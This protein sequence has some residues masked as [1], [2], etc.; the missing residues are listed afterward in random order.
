[1]TRTL[2]VVPEAR[3][4]R[5]A[6]GM[7]RVSDERG[8]GDA[9]LS[10]A[11]QRRSIE[12]YASRAGYDVVDWV[13][14][15]DT[16]GSR[17]RSAWWPRLDQTI[18]RI[19][20]GEA[21]VIVVW[22]FSRA[23]RHR[24]K[25]AMALDRVETAGGRLESATESTDATPAGRLSRGMIGEIAAYE[26]EI[27][28]EN[29]KSAHRIRTDRG[30][31][32]NGKPRWGYTY[33]TDE[34]LHRPDPD[35]GP[36]LAELYRRYVAGESVYSLVRWLNAAG[37]RTTP[38]YSKDGPGRWTDRSLRRMLDS[39]FG[40]GLILVHGEHR[41]GVHD[42]VIGRDLWEAY[43]DARTRRRVTRSSERSQYLLSGLV[44]C[45]H[46]LDGDST[47]GSAMTAGQFGSSHQPKYRC[48]GARE[49]GLHDGGYVTAA[50]LEEAV[51]D[52]LRDLAADV[53]AASAKAAAASRRAAR[54]REQDAATMEAEA[55]RIGEQLVRATRQHVAGVV[56]EAAYL[57]VRDELQEQL[58]VLEQRRR[59][60][61]VASRRGTADVVARELLAEW[62]VLSVEH[63]RGMLRTLIAR[64]E[65]R[66]GRPRAVV[67]IVPE[68]SEAVGDL[69][70]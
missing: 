44:R 66:P 41:D 56:P 40:A 11:I 19:E 18:D 49:A 55:A 23:A 24:L 54:R 3:T 7:V 14:G 42:P 45:V 46:V 68:W 69:T 29:W 2:T 53:S 39:G 59:T 6:I 15:I 48:K 61:Q 43:Q 57:E 65:V 58:E 64:V 4:R 12:E 32:A 70:A 25:W 63:R 51:L 13:E 22:K 37:F 5:R 20:A 33:D 30:R 10:P 31:P 36:V 21:D 52:W 27:I 28:G 34:K 16:S 62:D 17:A 47:C 8:R 35:T 60:L 9:L 26:A 1:M 38:G 50:Y 67:E